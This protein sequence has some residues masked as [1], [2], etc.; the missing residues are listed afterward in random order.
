MTEEVAE[1]ADADDEAVP[2]R[3]PARVYG[4]GVEPDAR[5]SLA[6][7][8]T[9]LAWIRTS[10]ALMA[11][12]VALQVFGVG[13]RSTPS[14]AASALLTGSAVVLPILAWTGW[15][16][17]ERSLR[18]SAPLPAPHIAVPLSLVLAVAAGLVCWSMLI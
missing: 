17:T 12:G 5:F 3:F 14:V 1:V 16:R 10:L 15:A 13:D 2:R 8:R 4:T 7:E 18:R 11:A 6:N 9:Y